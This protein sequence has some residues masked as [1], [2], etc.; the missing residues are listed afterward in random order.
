MGVDRAAVKRDVNVAVGGRWGSRRG[1]KQVVGG[2][3][4]RKGQRD[5]RGAARAAGRTAGSFLCCLWSSVFSLRL[6]FAFRLPSS[7]FVWFFSFFVLCFS[8]L[9]YESPRRK[10]G[11]RFTAGLTYCSAVIGRLQAS[12]KINNF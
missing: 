4:V 3:R 12:A 5:G 7:F 1:R 11:W 8:V 9:L 6:I 2:V 10:P